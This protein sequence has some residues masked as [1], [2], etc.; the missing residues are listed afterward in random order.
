MVS[1]CTPL[2][3][4]KVLDA[5][6]GSTIIAA[7]MGGYRYWDEVEKHLIG[8]DLYLDTTYSIEELGNEGMERLIKAHGLQKILFATDSPWSDLAK[9]IANIKSLNL[10]K[11]ELDGIL[12]GNARRILNLGIE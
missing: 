10:G 6:P 2:R 8:K 3:L 5:F 1:R 9:E 4:K 12:G 11:E 7:H